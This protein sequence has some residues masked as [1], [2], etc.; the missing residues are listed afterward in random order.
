MADLAGELIAFPLPNKPGM[1]AYRKLANDEVLEV[2][3]TKEEWLQ[4]HGRHHQEELDKIRA[5]DKHPLNQAARTV[6]DEAG[7]RPFANEICLISL[8]RYAL[9]DDT[10][11]WDYRLLA[12][13]DWSRSLGTMQKAIWMLEH[14]GVTPEDLLSEKL[15]DAA[16][17]ILRHLFE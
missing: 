12:L 15:E 3:L 10:P 11:N 7:E 16:E 2:Q 1:W 5:L 17:L 8:A 4:L 14:G 9:D 13:S 6:L